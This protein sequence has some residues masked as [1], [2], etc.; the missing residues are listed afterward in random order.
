MLKKFSAFLTT[1]NA[2]ALAIGVIIGAAVGK[3]VSSL[4]D[5]MIMPVVGMVLPAGDWREA[6]IVLKTATDASG[7]ITENAIRYGNFMGTL[8]EFLIIAIVVFLIVRALLK[9]AAAT[10]VKQC[11]ECREAIPVDARRCR[12]CATAL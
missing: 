6:K 11:P 7:R 8:L 3:V 2:M 4:V 9:P 12:A 5:D 1:S 10:P